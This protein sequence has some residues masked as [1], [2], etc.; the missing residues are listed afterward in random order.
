MCSET[1][2]HPLLPADH[3]GIV[4]DK[5]H[6]VPREDNRTPVSVQQRGTMSRDNTLELAT[7]TSELTQPSLMMQSRT[8]EPLPNC[9]PRFPIGPIDDWRHTARIPLDEP[10]G[11]D[12]AIYLTMI[13]KPHPY[14]HDPVATPDV[15]CPVLDSQPSQMSN[16]FKDGPS[17]AHYTSAPPVPE[18]LQSASEYPSSP[19]IIPL[20]QVPATTRFYFRIHLPNGLHKI[21]SGLTYTAFMQLFTRI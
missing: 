5:L 12:P 14:N 7:P 21:P 11:S 10:T 8:H 18:P 20:L 3:T 13:N 16:F 9:M 6:V 19:P 4:N 1:E 17:N 15:S 2:R